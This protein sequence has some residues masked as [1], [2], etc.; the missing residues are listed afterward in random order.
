[1]SGERR[2]HSEVGRSLHRGPSPIR[3]GNRVFYVAVEGE[4]T[5]PDYLAYLNKEFGEDHDFFIHTLSVGNGLKPLPCVEK[6]LEYEGEVRDHEIRYPEDDAR[7]P[8]LWAVFDR[9][10]H[11]GI[12]EAMKK[13]RKGD[14]RIAFSHPSFDLWLLLHFQDFSGAQDG[15]SAIVHEKLR[16]QPAFRRF[17]ATNA[18][19]DKALKGDRV[20]ALKER[21]GAARSRARRMTDDCSASLCSK[22]TGHAPHCDPLSRDPSTDVWRL[23]AELGIL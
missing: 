14:V 8:R 2:K 9:D 23:L 1:M 11:H 15:S 22:A 12:P 21:H 20:A 17:A 4:V 7:K 3:R 6:V 13:A 18:A 5:E 16:S 19:E 10:Q